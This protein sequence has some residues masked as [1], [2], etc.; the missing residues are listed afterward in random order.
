MVQLGSTIKYL[1]ELMTDNYDMDLPF[2]FMKLGISNGVWSLLVSHLQAWNFYYILPT[3][4]GIPVALDKEE[5]VV[6]T[7][8]KIGW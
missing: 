8:L 2:L 6:P 1:A 3:T 7:A 4:D 5:L